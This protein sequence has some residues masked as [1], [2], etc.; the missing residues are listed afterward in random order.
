[1]RETWARVTCKITRTLSQG[2]EQ[3]SASGN[4]AKVFDTIF[5]PGYI[6][7]PHQRTK[8]FA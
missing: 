3:L 4:L 6:E 5:S 1:M 8:I 2:Q 7:V